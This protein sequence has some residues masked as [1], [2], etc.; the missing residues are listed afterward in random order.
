MN[1]LSAVKSS[2]GLGRQILGQ[3]FR[4]SRI[5][6]D[7][8][9]MSSINYKSGDSLPHGWKVVKTTSVP[10]LSLPGING[11]IC[12]TQICAYFCINT[13]PTFI[14]VFVH[15]HTHAYFLIRIKFWLL[16]CNFYILTLKDVSYEMRNYL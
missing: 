8:R 6:K 11:C 5:L 12:S 14:C 16:M 10:E 15:M 1:R 3:G 9:F 2:L 13:Q 7:V 4:G